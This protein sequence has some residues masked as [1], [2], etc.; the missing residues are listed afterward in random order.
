MAGPNWVLDKGFIANGVIRQFRCVEVV[1]TN[2]DLCTEV[3]GSGD[4]VLGIS[5]EDVPATPATDIG[6][7][8]IDI[9]LMGISR[10]IAGAAV[11]I[12]ARVQSDAEGR[13]VALVAAGTRNAVGV[14]LTAAGAAGDHINVLLTPGVSVVV[15]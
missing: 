14:A 10:A 4:F 1:T 7:R 3:D 12:G 11:T 8:V 6:K 2:K 5:Q 15:A 9:R 13:V